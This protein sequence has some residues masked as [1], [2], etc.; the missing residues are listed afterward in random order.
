MHILA[1]YLIHIS[2]QNLFFMHIV[3]R[4]QFRHVFYRRLNL[5]W[6]GFTAYYYFVQMIPFLGRNGIFYVI[7]FP[8]I[9]AVNADGW[10]F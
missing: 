4:A 6:R 9:G 5:K 7:F 1:K 3:Q 10:R 8:S 2:Q